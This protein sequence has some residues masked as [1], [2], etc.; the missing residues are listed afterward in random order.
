MIAEEIVQAAQR[1]VTRTQW[2]PLLNAM[3]YPILVV[4]SDGRVAM[5]NSL[6]FDLLNYPETMVLGHLV[7]EF[8]P[9]RFRERHVQ[10]RTRYFEEPM[11]RP[12][13]SALDIF[14]LTRGGKEIQVDLGLAPL[15]IDEG[16][17]VT[18]TIQRK[19]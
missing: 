1:L 9:E 6:A 14:L 12:M 13:G 19:S 5:G 17:F 18:I 2:R 10:H 11:L 3:F 16:T 7:E 8:M 15:R 4:A